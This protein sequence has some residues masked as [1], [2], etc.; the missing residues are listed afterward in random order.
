M[1]IEDI[2]AFHFDFE[3]QI[4]NRPRFGKFMHEQQLLSTDLFKENQH[5]G[6][7]KLSPA[8]K[9]T[10][11]ER[12]WTFLPICKVVVVI[13]RQA[14]PKEVT[15]TQVTGLEVIGVQAF[16]E[17]DAWRAAE[18]A[19]SWHGVG[20]VLWSGLAA[21]VSPCGRRSVARLE[22]RAGL[23]LAPGEG[24]RAVGETGDAASVGLVT[25]IAHVAAVQT[26]GERRRKGSLRVTFWTSGTFCQLVRRNKPRKGWPHKTKTFFTCLSDLFKDAHSGT[27][28]PTTQIKQLCCIIFWELK[29]TM[30]LLGSLW[31]RVE[32]PRM[33]LS[34]VSFQKKSVF[35]LHYHDASVYPW[36]VFPISHWN[37]SGLEMP[38]KWLWASSVSPLLHN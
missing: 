4:D 24:W 33:S 25:V 3:M 19:A 18:V 35:T 17:L 9:K 14:L 28:S 1:Q 6:V 38:S 32:W 29:L 5:V 21:L 7:C 36:Q 22:S 13:V 16:H 30:Q 34:S 2:S 11:W 20:C 12:L 37:G 23:A 31:H 15:V 8:V 10:N 26:A 27:E